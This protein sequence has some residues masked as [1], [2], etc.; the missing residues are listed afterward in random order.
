MDYLQHHIE[1]L[2]FCSPEPLTV[3]DISIC[4]N[5]MFE[6]EVP[7][8]DILSTLDRIEQRYSAED[9]AF[10]LYRTGGGL[11]FLTK[12]AYQASIGLLLRQRSKKQLSTSALETL[13]IIAYRQPVTKAEMEQIRGVNCDYAVNRL[14]EKELVEIKGKSEG[15]GR[16]LLYGTSR[17]FMDH[18]G[19]NS[20]ADLPQLKDF[21]PEPETGQK[22][23]IIDRNHPTDS[24]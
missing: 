23:D 18:F 8:S 1:A 7:E 2:I 17:R 19:I 12:P 6:A 14:L 4:L 9:H 11:Q 15:V 13:S 24:K 22:Y 3:A 16:P 5:E 21:G 20:I 10:G